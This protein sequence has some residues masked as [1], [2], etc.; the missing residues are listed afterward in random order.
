MTDLLTK[1]LNKTSEHLDLD[2]ES[3][4]VHRDRWKYEYDTSYLLHPEES[5]FV[6]ISI[7]RSLIHSSM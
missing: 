6:V 4:L 1:H 7:L 5:H 2:D 3:E